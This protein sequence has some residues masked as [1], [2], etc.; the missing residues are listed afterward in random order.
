MTEKISK[1][2]GGCTLWARQTIESDI[3]NT[4]PAKWF[5]MWFYLV[6]RANH[7]D[8][9]QLKRGQCHLTYETIMLKCNATKSEVDHCMR[10]LKAR[11]MLGTQKTTRGFII[12]IYNYERYQNIENYKVTSL[13]AVGA[14]SATGKATQKQGLTPLDSDTYDEEHDACG[15]SKSD[16]KATQKRHDKQECKNVNNDRQTES[17]H[18]VFDY[19]NSF[20]GNSIRKRNKESNEITVT[21]RNH[22]LRTDGT[23]A[24]DVKAAI[25]EALKAGYS[26]T[27]IN[28]AIDNY[29]KILLDTN[30][31]WTHVWPL[32]IFLMVKYERRKDAEHKW[33]QFLPDN[34]D[35][36]K[37]LTEAAK[38]QRERQAK[39][40]VPLE[41]AKRQIKQDKRYK[42]DEQKQIA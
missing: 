7:I 9:N 1:I 42:T 21:W 18:Q 5:K 3:F 38:H 34:F 29:A 25:S 2:L 40:P 11:R 12:T 16:R 37:Y 33:W 17:V 10:W 32:S 36:N 41:M 23:I 6:N 13:Q 15:D 24:P 20:K 4:K 30:Y 27:E 39:G 28:A 14:K 26:V 8:N 35:E 22:K 19:W 31:W